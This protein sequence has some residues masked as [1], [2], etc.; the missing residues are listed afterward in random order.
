[1]SEKKVNIIDIIEARKQKN[2]SFLNE[3]GDYN[4]EKGYFDVNDDVNVFYELNEEDLN[5]T[6]DEEGFELCDVNGKKPY[7]INDIYYI[8]FNKNYI[9]FEFTGRS[10]FLKIQHNTSTGKQIEIDEK[11]ISYFY[12]NDQEYKFYLDDNIVCNF[13]ESV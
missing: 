9:Y 6:V 3:I 1:M 7:T 4:E 12:I 10:L 2:Y 11:E 5:A 13:L 8:E